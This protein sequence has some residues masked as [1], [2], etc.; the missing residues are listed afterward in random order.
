MTVTRARNAE[1]KRLFKKFGGNTA[2]EKKKNNNHL[3]KNVG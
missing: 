1:V 3:K 2:F